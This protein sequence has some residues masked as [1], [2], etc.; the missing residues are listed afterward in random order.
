MNLLTIL[1]KNSFS[2]FISLGA[3]NTALTAILYQVLLYFTSST[4]AYSLSWLTGFLI[5]VLLYPKYVFGTSITISSILMTSIIYLSSLFLGVVMFYYLDAS[6]MSPRLSIFLV[7]IV[8]SIYNY[9]LMNK[10]LMR[11]K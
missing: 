10:L 8:T 11:L 3:V 9:L 4:L 7:I 6:M 2:R 1:R 5:L